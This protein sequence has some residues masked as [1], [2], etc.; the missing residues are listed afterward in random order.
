MKLSLLLK[1]QDRALFACET[2]CGV[3]QSDAKDGYL[4]TCHSCIAA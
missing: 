1:D 4:K 3:L 2:L